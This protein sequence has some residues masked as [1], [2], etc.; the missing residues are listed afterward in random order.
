MKEF[1]VKNFIFSSTCAVYGMPQEL[2][3]TETHSLNPINPY[4]Q[5]KL[6]VEKILQDFDAAYGIKHINLRYFNAAGADLDAEIG[7]KHEPETHLIPLAIFAAQGKRDKLMVFGDDYDTKDGTCV[8]DYVHV[9]DLAEAHYKAFLYLKEHQKSDVFNLGNGDG[10]TVKEV[11]KTTEEVSGK[12]VPHSMTA[13]R[14]GDPAVLVG[15]AEK[16]KQVLGWS[17]RYSDLKAIVK[18]A[19]QWHSK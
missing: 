7:E 15:S 1:N 8:R 5:T 12:E 17:P 11:I 13:R 10:F 6:M 9:D 3:L 19:Y 14:A 18:S 16:A 2:P 4:G